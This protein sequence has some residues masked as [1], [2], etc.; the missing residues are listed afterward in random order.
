MIMSSL[1]AHLIVKRPNR[2]V[3]PLYRS[4]MDIRTIDWNEVW[5][6]LK[7]GHL[8]TEQAAHYW[9]RRATDFLQ[10]DATSPYVEQFLQLLSLQPHWQVLD[11]GCAAGTLALPLASRVRQVTGLDISQA[12]LDG[13][14]NS[15]QRQAIDNIRTV[16]ASWSDDWATAG[17]EQHEVAIAS[18]S[19]VVNDL[20]AAIERLNRFASRRVYLSTPVADGPLDRN[21][22]KAVGRPFRCGADYIVVYNLLYQM[23]LHATLHFITYRE[24]KIYSGRAAVFHSLS[25]KI[26]NLRPA[27]EMALHSYIDRFYVHRPD[28]WQRATP[29]LIRWAV[30]EWEIEPNE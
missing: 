7:N 15:C 16:Q 24:D 18:R 2:M 29:R 9:N 1:S 6:D 4:L 20:R 26:G 11:V 8:E 5:Q 10:V 22:F 25:N 21:L 19:L 23:G 28:G 12:M 3:S 30:M 27:E 14:R 17:I 13:L